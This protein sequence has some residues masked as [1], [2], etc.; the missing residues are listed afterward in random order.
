MGPMPLDLAAGRAKIG[1]IHND[2]LR[3]VAVVVTRR[4]STREQVPLVDFIAR[5]LGPNI[6]VS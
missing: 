5:E 3:V 2:G 4:S 1:L 6:K